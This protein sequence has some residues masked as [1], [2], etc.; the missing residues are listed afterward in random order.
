MKAQTARAH[1]N[2]I[3]ITMANRN[4]HKLRLCVWWKTYLENRDARIR[5]WNES[6]DVVVV[7]VVA[8][9]PVIFE[10][11]SSIVLCGWFRSI[12]NINNDSNI[13]FQFWV[14]LF[15]HYYFLLLFLLRGRVFV[16]W[17]VFEIHQTFCRNNNMNH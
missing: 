17:I 5:N 15:F 13:F 7:A 11:F 4:P 12:S 14:M 9:S 16:V 6:N 2:V 8:F 3:S 1:T 10:L